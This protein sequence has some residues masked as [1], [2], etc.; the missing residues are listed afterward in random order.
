MI[1]W[2]GNNCLYKGRGLLETEQKQDLD[3]LNE[4][5]EI[6]VEGMSQAKSWIAKSFESTKRHEEPVEVNE[7][8]A[9]D[10]VGGEDRFTISNTARPFD[11]DARS[12]ASW[13]SWATE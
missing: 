10:A 7:A 9:A 3:R 13:H 2:P 4:E 1:V 11:D 8:T 5:V 6:V 12:V